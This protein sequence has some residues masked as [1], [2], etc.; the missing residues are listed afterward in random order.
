MKVLEANV[1]DLGWIVDELKC[2]SDEYGGSVPMFSNREY[3]QETIQKYIESHVVF[4]AKKKNGLKCGFI[5]GFLSEH[6]YNPDII[7]LAENFWW[8][9]KQYRGSRAGLLLLNRFIEFGKNFCDQIVFGIEAK[10]P[11][12]ED[13]LTKRGFKLHE[14]NY[15]MEIDSGKR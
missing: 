10:C 13:A 8:V 6:I 15:I 12:N 4:I 2:F 9:P 11:I 14:R 1:N 7:V 5:C 3:A